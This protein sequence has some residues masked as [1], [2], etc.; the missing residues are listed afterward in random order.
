MS[1]HDESRRAFLVGTVAGAGAVATARGLVR[2]AEAQT[3]ADHTTAHDSGAK[4]GAFLNL[5]DA[6]AI[7]A[8]TERLMPG[9][10]GKPGARD[11]GV[12]NYIDL[13]LAGA[14]ED[15]QDF[16]RRG[17]CCARSALP[18]G[19]QEVVRAA[20]GRRSG[21]SDQGDG[22]RAR[23]RASPGLRR[24]RSSTRCAP[25][26]SKACLRTR[27]M[28]ATRILPA[29]SWSAS[30]AR[31]RLSRQRTCRARTRSPARPWS[32]CRRAR[33]AEPWPPKKRMS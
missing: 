30:P 26:R 10:P 24:R 14:Y 12:L 17:L 1:K 4:L 22:S 19:A 2:E 31:S 11:A 13:A 29:G 20:F 3:P 9:A 23:P 21:R 8:F 5:D 32:A 33:G 15:Q 16:Y 7:E 27:S 18:A 25:I 6:A 28:A